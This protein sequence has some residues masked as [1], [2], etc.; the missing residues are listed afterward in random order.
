MRETLVPILVIALVAGGGWYFREPLM[1]QVNASRGSLPTTLGG[2]QATLPAVANEPPPS[3]DT[4]YRWVDEKGVVHYDQQR[5]AGSQAVE[6]DQG[7]IQSLS[8]YDKPKT[9]AHG[10]PLV[11]ADGGGSRKSMRAADQFPQTQIVNP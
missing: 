2:Q 9:D 10:T 8:Q 11:E 6:I 4:I 1:K 3:K 5:V 7:R